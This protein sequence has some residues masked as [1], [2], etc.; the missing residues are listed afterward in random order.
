MKCSEINIL[1]YLENLLGT[2]DKEQTELHLEGCPDCS[3]QMAEFRMIREGARLIYPALARRDCVSSNSIRVFLDDEMEPEDVSRFQSHLESCQ[4]CRDEVEM[5]GTLYIPEQSEN[6]EKDFLGERKEK[7]ASEAKWGGVSRVAS[8]FADKGRYPKTKSSS[9]PEAIAPPV[10]DSFSEKR[11]ARQAEIEDLRKRFDIDRAKA[12]MDHRRKM[13][14]TIARHQR[15][16]DRMKR[17]FEEKKKKLEDET[18][19]RMVKVAIARGDMES[20]DNKSERGR[21]ACAANNN[22]SVGKAVKCTCGANIEA[23]WVFCPQC[24]RTLK[25]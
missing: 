13:E 18:A 1:G 14:E 25:A 6:R 24:G 19:T 3:R 10:G 4:K 2:I 7:T 11:T 16:M 23:R 20:R 8:V 12:D 5:I 9:K 21:S 17:E 15:E 22:L